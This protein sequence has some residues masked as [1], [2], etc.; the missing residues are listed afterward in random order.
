MA[1]YSDI[2]AALE[3]KLSAF[4]TL[5]SYSVAW[6]NVKFEPASEPYLAAFNLPAET[7]TVGLENTSSND[8]QGIYQIDVRCKKGK[9]GNESRTIVDAVLGEFSKGSTQTV[10]TTKVVI[11]QS[12][13]SGSFDIDDSWFVVPVSVKYRALA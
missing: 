11:Q 13:A 4:A 12:W 5:N 9:G 7:T 1:A 3:T 6:P 10:N 2:Q 8:Y